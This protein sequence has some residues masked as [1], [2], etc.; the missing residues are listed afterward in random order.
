MPDGAD[1][2]ALGT[3]FTRP[4]GLQIVGNRHFQRHNG[5]DIEC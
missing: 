2:Q 5:P 4:V 1:A 3:A